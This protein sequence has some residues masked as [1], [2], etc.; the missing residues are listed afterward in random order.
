M[1]GKRKKHVRQVPKAS[2]SDEESP[3]IDASD[4]HRVVNF[5]QRQMNPSQEHDET[6][7][8]V[9][10]QQSTPPR[11]GTQPPATQS[12]TGAS[13]VASKDYN[14]RIWKLKT[15]DF[16]ILGQYFKYAQDWVALMS[17]TY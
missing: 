3:N 9:I 4:V 2:S 17:Q 1:S 8:S 12:E 6:Q 13:Q 5:S 14:N 15:V 10:R 7:N 11:I 16:R